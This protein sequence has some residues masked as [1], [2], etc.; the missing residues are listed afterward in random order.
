VQV[1][2]RGL[3]GLAVAEVRVVVREERELVGPP[4]DVED[5]ADAAPELRELPAPL[6]ADAARGRVEER[7]LAGVAA[8]A[9]KG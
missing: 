3:E 2:E 7:D 4:R 8:W 1:R 6:R 5:A 9:G